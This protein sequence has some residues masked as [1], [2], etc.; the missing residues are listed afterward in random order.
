MFINFPVGEKL[1][2]IESSCESSLI[3]KWNNKLLVIGSSHQSSLT[4]KTT[5]KLLAIQLGGLIRTHLLPIDPQT[6]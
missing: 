2:E 3:L 4:P 6:S 1:L 5:N